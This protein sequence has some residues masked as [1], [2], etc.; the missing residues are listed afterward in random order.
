V[1][2]R[3]SGHECQPDVIHPEHLD[4][5]LALH[6]ELIAGKRAAYELT[7]WLERRLGC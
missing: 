5:Q 4:E 3:D 1:V 7:P 6:A 2:P